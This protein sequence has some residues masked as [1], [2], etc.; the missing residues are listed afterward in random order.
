[1]IDIEKVRPEV[2]AVCRRFPVKRLGLFGSAVR[3]DFAPD[4]DVD[5][6][7]VF[8]E[9]ERG[10]VFEDY[11]ELKEGL[12][13]VFGRAVDLVMDKDFRN[14]VLRERINATRTVIYER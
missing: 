1:M 6:L 8:D 5:V 14:P 13:Q 10:D 12:E 2:E 3:E 4:S 9:G 7:V 11:F